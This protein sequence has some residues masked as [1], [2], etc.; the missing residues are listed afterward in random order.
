MGKTSRTERMVEIHEFY[1]IRSA[2]GS[3]PALCGEC[4]TGDAIMVAPEQAAAIAAVP[5]RTIYLWVETDAVHYSETPDRSIIVCVKSLAV[6][7]DQVRGN[8]R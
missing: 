6:T 1:V 5:V 8:L 3:L 2:S 4:S 7:G